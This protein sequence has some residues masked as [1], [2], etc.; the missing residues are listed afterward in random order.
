MSDA[1]DSGIDVIRGCIES[2]ERLLLVANTVP[3]DQFSTPW[4]RHNGI[5]PHLR[6]CHEHLAAL[7]NG[8]G[9]R[10]VQH[11]VRERNTTLERDPQAFVAALTPI[12]QWLEGLDPALLETPLTV[13]QVPR[14]DAP[15][16]RSE[17]TLRRELLFLTSHTIHHLALVAMLAE[18]QGITLPDDL[19]VAYSTTTHDHQQADGT[20]T[21]TS[22]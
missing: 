18:V 8:F 20:A 4:K 3:R 19:G 17:S 13:C 6:H 15:E 22:S 7:H 14:V 16:T 21:V 9:A 10:A 1:V 2:C 5:G 11:D 12:V